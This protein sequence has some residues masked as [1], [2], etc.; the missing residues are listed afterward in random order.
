MAYILVFRTDINSTK[1]LYQVAF[2][3]CLLLHGNIRWS[4]DM[5]DC[6]CV[7]RI[8]TDTVTEAEVISLVEQDKLKCEPLE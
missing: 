1:R 8:E 4:V 5:E 2:Q 6:D 7:L 3:L